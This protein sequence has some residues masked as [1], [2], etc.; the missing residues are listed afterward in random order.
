[1][2]AVP[3]SQ[4][5]LGDSLMDK[6]M[7]DEI[8]DKIRALEEYGAAPSHREVSELL[9]G[10]LAPLLREDGYHLSGAEQP[11]EEDL[12][13]WR[14]VLAPKTTRKPQSQSNISTVRK[15]Q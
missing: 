11:Y 10:I 5:H 13:S 12:T 9:F 4:H 3:D 2:Y 14:R 6:C 15:T 8:R 7:R 1:M